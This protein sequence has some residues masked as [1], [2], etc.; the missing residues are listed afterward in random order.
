MLPLPDIHM[1]TVNCGWS[2]DPCAV[3]KEVTDALCA[4]RQVGSFSQFRC[5]FDKQQSTTL[6]LQIQLWKLYLKYVASQVCDSGEI[7]Q[8][9]GCC[10]LPFNL[11]QVMGSWWTM[12]A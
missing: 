10:S 8:C 7:F 5:V 1:V 9:N 3:T 6:V 2:S 11:L 4:D 12:K